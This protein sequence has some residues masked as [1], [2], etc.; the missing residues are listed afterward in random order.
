M[1]LVVPL[2]VHGL[3]QQPVKAYATQWIRQAARSATLARKLPLLVQL[4][5]RI[6]VEAD[7]VQERHL[8]LLQHRCL[9]PQVLR[10]RQVRQV[11]GIG[12]VRQPHLLGKPLERP[13][14][15]W[16]TASVAVSIG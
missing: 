10:V 5:T 12:S 7:L 13:P 2:L 9:L 3:V 11:W 14:P 6:G 15:P 16:E 4:A 8:I 1:L